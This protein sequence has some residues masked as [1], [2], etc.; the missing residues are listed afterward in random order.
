MNQFGKQSV[1]ENRATE[2]VEATAQSSRA[3][4]EGA[5]PKGWSR[6]F[7]VAWPSPM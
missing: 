4:G 6:G 2:E 5:L 3:S 1:E 7:P